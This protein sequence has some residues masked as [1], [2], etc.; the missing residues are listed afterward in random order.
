MLSILE[1]MSIRPGDHVVQFYERDADLVE[2]VGDYLAAGLAQGAAAV[3][4]ATPA[5]REAF[6][7]R[8]TANGV[9]TT[10][11]QLLDAAGTLDRLISAGRLDRS[12]FFDLIGGVVRTAGEGGRVVCAYGEMVALLWEAG[13][14]IA[15]IELETLWNELAAELPFSL[16]CGYHSDSVAGHGHADALHQVCG[17]HA[18]VV[19]ADGDEVTADFQVDLRAVAE[20]R[21]LV[22]GAVQSWG[23][24]DDLVADARLVV[25]ELAT[26]AILHART[27]FRISAQRFGPAV[28]ISVRDHATAMPAVLAP[29]ALSTSGRGMLLIGALARRWGVEVD[30]GGKT[31]WAELGR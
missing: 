16:Y 31:V 15:A 4:I 7:D 18:A 9:D 28:R 1:P 11:L 13:D 5:H 29:D 17:L 24:D 21:L 8:L 27:A 3:V 30:A 10:A 2:R 25:T 26:N 14:V 19:P 22:A 20:A 6:T 12:A 23:H